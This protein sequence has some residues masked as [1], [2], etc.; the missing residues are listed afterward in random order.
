MKPFLIYKYS[1]DDQEVQDDFAEMIERDQSVM[2]VN[3]G[4]ALAGLTAEQRKTTKLTMGSTM[5]SK[6]SSGMK[7]KLNTEGVQEEYEENKDDQ[8]SL[9]AGLLKIA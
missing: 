4:A 3:F 2:R 9:K 6:F 1:A 8:D 7:K 5:M